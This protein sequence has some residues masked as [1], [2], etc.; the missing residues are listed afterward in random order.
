MA[1]T[2]PRASVMTEFDPRWEWIKV[3][4]HGLKPIYVKGLCNHIDTTPV[5]TLD[6]EHVAQICLTC[7]AELPPAS[8]NALE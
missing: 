7:D 6:G 1:R 3:E 5:V 8:P 4:Q 2:A